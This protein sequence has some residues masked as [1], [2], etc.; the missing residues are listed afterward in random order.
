M[1]KRNT[2]PER[3]AEVPLEEQNSLRIKRLEEKLYSLE[4]SPYL[5][6]AGDCSKSASGQQIGRANPGINEYAGSS[7][8]TRPTIGESANRIHDQIDKVQALID[9]LANRLEGISTSTVS[10][11]APSSPAAPAPCSFMQTLD[12]A[13]ERLA[14]VTSKLAYILDN[15]MI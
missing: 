2:R 4:T 5:I 12:G 10:V 3:A 15:L 9:T 14:M 7:P 8:P 1:V 6:G 11:A 13:R